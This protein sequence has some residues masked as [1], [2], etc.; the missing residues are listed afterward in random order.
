MEIN[1]YLSCGFNLPLPTRSNPKVFLCVNDR[2]VA[3]K[4]FELYNPFSFQGKVLKFFTRTLYVYFNSFGRL[5]LTNNEIKSNLLEYIENKL[6]DKLFSSAYIATVKDKFVF[7]LQNE[8]KVVGYVK[9]PITLTGQDRIR[10]EEKAIE[11]LS[12]KGI[13]PH[14]ILSDRFD[15]FTFLILPNIEGEVIQ[16]NKSEYNGILKKF[17]KHVFFSLKSHPRILQIKYQLIYYNYKDL[18]ILLDKI[19]EQSCRKYAEVY[20]HG[21]FAPWNLK[22]TK[23]GIIPFDFE[24]FEEFGLENL[25]EIKYHYQIGTLLLKLRGEKLVKYISSQLP[26]EEFD[27]IFQIYLIKEIIRKSKGDEN[28]QFEKS[29]L[30][31]YI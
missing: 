19:I 28:F 15:G 24:Y 9:F 4:S 7:Q 31:Q 8:Q 21:D 16:L 13:V 1:D 30:K 3:K 11:I 5:F 29:L 2:L 10:N 27:L 6:N 25:D 12:K 23:S 17:N 18:E 26:I 22:K 14:A 20:E